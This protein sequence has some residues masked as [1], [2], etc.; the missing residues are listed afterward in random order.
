MASRSY[1]IKSESEHHENYY[2]NPNIKNDRKSF[3]HFIKARYLFVFMGFTAFNLVYA[4]KVVLSVAI[5][6]M[7]GHQTDNNNNTNVTGQCL[8]SN[9]G[10]DSSSVKPG[11]FE[12]TE[13]ER[14]ILLGAFF[15]G[16]VITQ[17]PAGFLS[18]RYGAKWIFGVA[19]FVTALLSLLIP[20]AARIH[21]L[22]LFG[23]R[24]LQGKFQL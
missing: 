13:N 16:Y 6:A 10:S 2:I 15:Y 19:M 8:A 4:Y 18:E 14:S 3:Y 7:V 24:F 23:A 9:S 1:N 5:V 20:L 12:W 22:A 11:Q 17:L 21:W